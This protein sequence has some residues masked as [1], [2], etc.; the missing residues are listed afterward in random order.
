MK[1]PS[2]GRAV[3][4]IPFWKMSGSGNDF[5]LIDNRSRLLSSEGA[6]PFVK[7]VCARGLS[8]GADG[9]ILIEP[10]S[11]ADFAWHFYNADGSEAEMCGNGGRCAARF[12]HLNQIVQSP[13]MRFET[14]AG[15]IEA[16]V[17]ADR[18]RV[19]LTDPTDFRRD[20]K[21]VLAQREYT[22]HYINTGV[23]HLVIPV[24]DVAFID[25]QGLGR[26]GRYHPLF[27]P[28]GTNVNFVSQSGPKTVQIRTYERGVEGETLACGTGSVAA[29]LVLGALGKVQSP[30]ALMT[31]GGILLN[32]DYTRDADS[33]HHVYLEGDARIVS[34]GEMW[35]EAWQ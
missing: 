19:R 18:V 12:A 15:I 31:R 23:P 5:I 9:L 20:L 14:K 7:R 2:A 16:E 35:A 26:E 27:A 3:E 34:V 10:S 24:D 21:L 28:K 17:K 4:K 13:R 32:V 25:L 22:G 6:G 8:V 30:V 33:F 1:N 29:A 11:R